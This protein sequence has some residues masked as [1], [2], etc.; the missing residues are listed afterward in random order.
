MTHHYRDHARTLDRINFS[1]RCSGSF[2]SACNALSCS[3]MSLVRLGNLTTS[4]T[5]AACVSELECFLKARVASIQMENPVVTCA[6]RKDKDIM[7]Q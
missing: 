6:T 2:S 7:T 4:S 3:P 5:A 1:T